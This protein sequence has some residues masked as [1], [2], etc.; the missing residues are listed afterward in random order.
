MNKNNLQVPKRIM[1]IDDDPFSLLLSK[2]KLRK[3]VDEKNIHE[4]YD[5]RNALEFLAQNLGKESAM[6]PDLI[7][8]EV[9]MDN[10]TGWDFIPQFSELIAKHKNL[11]IY[12]MVLTSS[13]FFSD[14]KKTTK[15]EIVKGFLMKPFHNELLLEAYKNATIGKVGAGNKMFHSFIV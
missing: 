8:L 7:L 9:M 6:I 2:M 4:Y 1:I 15:Y 12:L 10:E 11:E 14:Y 13:Q 5:T 3:I